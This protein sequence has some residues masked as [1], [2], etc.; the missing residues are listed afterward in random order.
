MEKEKFQAQIGY[1]NSEKR[2][3]G[4]EG[5]VYKS[6]SWSATKGLRCGGGSEGKTL[7]GTLAIHD[8]VLGTKLLR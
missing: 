2:G 6:G 1:V 8:G 7:E 5:A 3:L 4:Q